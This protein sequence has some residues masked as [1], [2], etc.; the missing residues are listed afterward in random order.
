ML[1]RWSTETGQGHLAPVNC[2]WDR[3]DVM[4]RGLTGS[5]EVDVHG[6]DGYF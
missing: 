3:E 2:R 5:D 1:S 4:L 6:T